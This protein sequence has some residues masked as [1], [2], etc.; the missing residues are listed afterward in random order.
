MRILFVQKDLFERSI[1]GSEFYEHH[2]ARE[3]RTRHDVRILCTAPKVPAEGRWRE[4]NAGEPK[5]FEVPANWDLYPS[6][7]RARAV[8]AA[9]AR[10]LDEFRPEIVHVQDLVRL[11]LEIPR[12]A[13]NRGVPVLLTA[14]EFFLICPRLIL[15]TSRE[16]LCDGPSL[17]GC[18]RCGSDMARR[19]YVPKQI[20]TDRW[21]TRIKRQGKA[22][23]Q[24]RVT[25]S[26]FALGRRRQFIETASHIE[27]ILCPS[28]FLRDRLCDAGVP[29]AKCRVIGYGLPDLGRPLAKTQSP[30]TR[31]AFIGNPAR[32]KGIFVLLAA[33]RAA[34]ELAITIYGALGTDVEAAV[35]AEI[36]TLPN[37]RLAGVLHDDAKA[38]AYSSIDALIVP[39]IWYENQPI[40]ILEAFHFRTPVVASRLGGMEEMLRHGG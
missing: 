7:E 23:V 34:P 11:S 9:F 36:G 31:F 29:A 27:R 15:R 2:L 10:I 35:R 30:R 1:G 19:R 21:R 5:A 16:T 38:E 33:A 28:A 25:E 14:H 26:Y 13:A 40:T 6:A 32:H 4:E 39:S 17:L 22:F 20:A 37:V 24:R 3:L 18:L 12:I 8:E